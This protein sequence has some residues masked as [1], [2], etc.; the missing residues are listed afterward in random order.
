MNQ[1]EDFFDDLMAGEELEAN[2][3]TADGDEGQQL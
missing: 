3:G 2:E 1:E